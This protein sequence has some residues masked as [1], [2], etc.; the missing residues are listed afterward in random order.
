MR[1]LSLFSRR[2]ATLVAFGSFAALPGLAATGPWVE[3]PEVKVRLVSGWSAV[4]PASGDGE[5][6]ELDLGV[7]FELLPGWHVYW[8]N[9]GDAGYAPKLDLA[10]TP[11][12]G[13]AKLL[14]PAPNRFDLPGGL[15]SF[16]YEDKVIYPVAG[17]L[18][19]PTE[20]PLAIRARLDYLVCAEECI[21]YTANLELALPAATDVVNER[22][23]VDVETADRLVRWRRALP[24]PEG[25]VADAPKVTVHLERADYPFSTLE[26][27]ATGGSFRASSPDLFFET[28]DF[29]ALG[30]PE[31]SISGSGLKF[32][33]PMRPL[34]ETKPVPAMTE[35]AWTLTGLEGT[36]GPFAMEGKSAVSIPTPKP[37]RKLWW[38]GTLVGAAAAWIALRART[39]AKTSNPSHKEAS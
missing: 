1:S 39:A 19:P 3:N 12:I 27:L 21:P 33:V 13:A 29:F 15:V 17:R 18:R 20:G 38:I 4:P 32:S 8:K 11:E 2:L 35:L 16:G 9:S 31:L 25:R 34:D 24:A 37:S 10:A 5:M 28:H 6:W 36:D 22:A 30:R 7:E 23:A 26:I 14:F